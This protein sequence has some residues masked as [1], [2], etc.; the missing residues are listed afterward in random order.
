MAEFRCHTQ[1]DESQIFPGPSG[2][3]Y[4]SR[5]GDF[6]KVDNPKDVEFFASFPKRFEQKGVARVVVD[7]VVGVRPQVQESAEQSLYDFLVNIKGVG[8]KAAESMVECYNTKED[9]IS[10]LE[11]GFELR[12]DIS[13]KAKDIIRKA[14]GFDVDGSKLED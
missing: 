5:R 11:Q 6:F 1:Q 13:Q 2:Q 7:K 9:V 4:F 12:A 10:D 14:L 8:K 3:R